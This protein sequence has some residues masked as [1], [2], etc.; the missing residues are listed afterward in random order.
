MKN[1]LILLL[2]YTFTID[3][4]KSIDLEATSTEEYTNADTTTKA[5][6]LENLRNEDIEITGKVEEIKNNDDNPGVV[7]PLERI[8]AGLEELENQ[9]KVINDT[10]NAQDDE[11]TLN[12]NRNNQSQS[13]HK[14]YSQ[15][16][17]RI[18][19]FSKPKSDN[20]KFNQ[21]EGSK[22]KSNQ[23]ATNNNKSNQTFH[24]LPKDGSNEFDKSHPKYKMFENFPIV[25][26][27]TTEQN[28]VK[29][30]QEPT[31]NV[32]NSNTK[33]LTKRIRFPKMVP[34]KKI[35]FPV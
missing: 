21:P 13:G 24:H 17:V 12:N 9:K 22:E 19:R 20:D 29:T 35:R 25:I 2:L 31:K 27:P 18:N 8:L 28:L 34:Q 16:E 11:E 26:N 23:L 7:I 1:Y 10:K 6:L 5:D 4:S 3:P 30:N 15:P 32:V 14:R 33:S